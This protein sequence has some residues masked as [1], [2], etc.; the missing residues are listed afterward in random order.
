MMGNLIKK[1][2]NDDQLTIYWVTID[3]FMWVSPKNLGIPP[4]IQNH[5]TNKSHKMELKA[6]S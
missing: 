6:T 1:E 3:V 4:N 2:T 5:P